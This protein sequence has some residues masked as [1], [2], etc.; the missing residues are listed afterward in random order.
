[1]PL[2]NAKCTN[3]GANIRVDSREDAAICEFC[4]SAFVVEKAINNYSINNN[5]KIHA[6]VVNIYEAK[7]PTKHKNLY[8]AARRARESNDFETAV[9]F[10]EKICDKDPVSWEA[11]FFA[12]YCGIRHPAWAPYRQSIDIIVDKIPFVLGLIRDNINDEQG[13]LNAVNIV[14]ER[15]LDYI[16]AYVDTMRRYYNC[17]ESRNS[18]GQK[19]DPELIRNLRESFSTDYH[20][21]STALQNISNNTQRIFGIN[22]KAY[23]YV[24]ITVDASMLHLDECNKLYLENEYK[25]GGCY[26]ATCVYGSYDCPQVWTL[27]R[28]RD[29]TLLATW[30]GKFFI[31]IYYKVSPILV[32]QFG[33]TKWFK[34]IWQFS[35]DRMVEKLQK[36]GIEST[37]YHDKT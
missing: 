17:R 16:N 28:F 18:V 9:K 30:Y 21:I 36:Q 14:I 10:Y 19:N 34:K 20:V 32:K 23:E 13:Q 15:T 33:H 12:E 25:S 35:L 1:M 5:N 6:N 37:P 27:R 29:D 7:E 24:R 2:S 26:I 11:N 31:Q 3:C 22:S 8:Q 4:G